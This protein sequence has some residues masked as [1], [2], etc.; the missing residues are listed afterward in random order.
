M[1]IRIHENI[2]GAGPFS[3]NTLGQRT[4]ASAYTPRHP[5]SQ[6]YL[7]TLFLLSILSSGLFPELSELVP[8]QIVPV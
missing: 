1:T 8:E 6:L 3:A 2:S 7:E 5:R 4:K